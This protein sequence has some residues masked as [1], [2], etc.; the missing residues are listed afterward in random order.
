MTQHTLRAGSLELM[1]DAARG[2]SILTFRDRGFDLM[3]P[4]DG[5]SDDPRTFASF[6]LVPFSGQVP[7]HIQSQC[8]SGIFEGT[9][10]GFPLLQQIQAISSDVRIRVRVIRN[11]AVVSSYTFPVDDLY[12]RTIDV[13]V[14]RNNRLRAINDAN[15]V[16]VIGEVVVRFPYLFPALLPRGLDTV[17]VPTVF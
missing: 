1:V 8:L 10:V 11:N 14:T 12:G 17:Y 2:G 5:V 3:R 13:D 4:W 15:G 7:P 6:P 16:V 9:S